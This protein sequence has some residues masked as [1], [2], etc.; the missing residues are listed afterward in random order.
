MRKLDKLKQL[1]ASI[2]PQIAVIISESV[3]FSGT[4]RSIS[5]VKKSPFLPAFLIFSLLFTISAAAQSQQ[6]GKSAVKP[7]PA[8]KTAP[9]EVVRS[10]DIELDVA[11]ALA[12]IENNYVAGKK[13]NYNEVVKSSIDG[14]LHSLDPHSNYFDA[15]EFEQFRTDQS[16]RYFGIGATIG[17]LSDPDGKVVATFIRATFEN[18]PAHRAGLRFGDKIVEVNG[19]NVLGKAFPDVRNMLRGPRGTPVKLVVERHGTGVRE[20]VNIVRDAVPQPSIPEAYMIRPG[21]GY[22]SM[23]GGFNQT[24]YAEFAEAMKRLKAQGMRELVLD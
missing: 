21:V 8:T 7:G 1:F 16:S 10:Q 22:I 9:G 2:F 12:V 6:V 23:T 3:A 15:K 13:I 19:T 11:E 14:M 20:T 18:A 24:T 4:K 5:R 17:D